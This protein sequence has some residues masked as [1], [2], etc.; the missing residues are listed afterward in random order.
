MFALAPFEKN[1]YFIPYWQRSF[2]GLRSSM[3]LLLIT[4]GAI[5]YIINDRDYQVHV[6]VLLSNFFISAHPSF[7]HELRR[8][9]DGQRTPG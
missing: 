4:G 5:A 1:T 3:G 2:P 7:E 6:C 9:M 8:R